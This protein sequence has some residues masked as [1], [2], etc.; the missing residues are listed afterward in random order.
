MCSRLFALCL[1]LW[2][3]PP[4]VRKPMKMKKQIVFNC[5][6]PFGVFWCLFDVFSLCCVLARVSFHLPCL[7]VSPL[8]FTWS[9]L[10]CLFRKENVE[11]RKP[12]RNPR[13]KERQTTW[14][15]IV[16]DLHYSKVWSVLPT[17]RG[18]V[19]KCAP[20]QL[21]FPFWCVFM[22]FWCVFPLLWVLFLL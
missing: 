21:C 12:Y 13:K 1:F 5:F 7:D 22:P 2:E 9:P 8:V 20:F 10:V 17:C 19:S 16:S 6:F 15:W 4:K 14:Q 11:I 3:K 18:W